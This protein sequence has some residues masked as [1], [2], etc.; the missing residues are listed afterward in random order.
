MK[1]PFAVIGFSLFVFQYLICAAGAGTSAAVLII[2]AVA[3]AAAAAV[4]F[5]VPGAKRSPVPVTVLCV[6][7]CAVSASGA[8]ALSEKY[9][10]LPVEQYAG[11]PHE[12]TGFVY[13]NAE[14]QD[15]GRY[16][17][18]V[19]VTSVD[20]EARDFKMRLLVF[21]SV[22]VSPFDE[23]A[24]S[25]DKTYD[26][27][28][29][30][31]A[32]KSE[33]LFLG[34]YTTG[35]VRVTGHRNAPV[36][37][38]ILDIRNRI[39]SYFSQRTDGETASLLTALTNGDRA[40]IDGALVNGLRYCGASHLFVVS[41][42]H[43]SFWA[44]LLM[45]LLKRMRVPAA[46]RLVVSGVFLILL[47]AL[48]GFGVSA[49]R[50]AVM[51]FIV[52]LGETVSRRSD[53]LNSLGFA[54]ALICLTSP[55]TA[56][57]ISF[58]LSLCSVA[59]IAVISVPMADHLRKTYF[60]RKKK[61][62]G[63]FPAAL[64]DLICVSLGANIFILPAAMVNFG[65]ISALAIP[66]TLILILPVE[67]AMIG[68][69]LALIFSGVPVIGDPFLTLARSCAAVVIRAVKALS[70]VHGMLIPVNSVW[71]AAVF[72]LAALAAAILYYRG[73]R[74]IRIAGYYACVGAVVLSLA[75]SS[76]VF[77]SGQDVIVPSTGNNSC[78]IV[79]DGG[80]YY[81]IGCGGS[82]SDYYEINRTLSKNMCLRLDRVIIPRANPT[83]SG[84]L[85]Y[86]L[87]ERR[88]DG[89]IYLFNGEYR[90]EPYATA[91]GSYKLEDGGILIEAVS[92]ENVS[93]CYVKLKKKTY[94]IS[95]YPAGDYSLVPEY[96]TAADVLI[97]RAAVPESLDASAFGE[98]Y[99]C[100][101]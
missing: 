58:G 64:T 32:A 6:L 44:G 98:I 17:L 31:Q 94:L 99:V 30:V 85:R 24:F 83:E 38:F 53:T 34:G 48:T 39:A 50:A 40:G 72:C 89:N 46:A 18:P 33:G 93:C 68:G 35:D 71:I 62:L 76:A 51:L 49:V 19:R 47:C 26:P 79:R 74:K 54:C 29:D 82:R 14:K 3:S 43:I 42:M 10:Y 80:R 73:R 95:F 61:R 55:Y 5:F 20:G 2:S 9:V 75:M 1:R 41:G 16:T 65:Y 25:T 96:F 100:K 97:A 23:I 92:N 12:F 90:P 101:D 78:V 91:D 52:Y 63:R 70:A 13:G 57:N 4:F 84:A 56:R 60:N 7:L 88:S 8:Y 59:G 22:D 87:D 11:S 69:F 36:R 21:T 81:M 66:S 45:I 37:E 15:G 27:S 86:L 77:Y 28:S 67:G